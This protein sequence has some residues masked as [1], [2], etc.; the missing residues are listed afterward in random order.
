MLAAAR[1]GSNKAWAALV[2]RVDPECRR[3]AHLVLGGH[4]V[5]RALLSAY[6]RAYR[7]RRKG[8]PDAV[9]FLTHHVWIACGHEI[10]RHQRREAPAPGRRAIRTDRRPR[11]G[12]DALGQAVAGLRPEERAVWGLVDEA[13]F[14]VAAV[15]QALG[16]DPKV[17][18]T[19]ASRVARLI[20]EALEEPT[21]DMAVLGDDDDHPDLGEPGDDTSAVLATEPSTA[22][23][24][25]TDEDEPPIEPEDAGQ[26]EPDPPDAAKHA[27]SA[28]GRQQ[29]TQ[30][31]AIGDV[32]ASDRS[33]PVSD[34]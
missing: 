1:Q 5:D 14:P 29:R 25:S 30:F 34:G 7:A 18:T 10:R 20:D 3:L 31:A 28:S 22:E 4:D 24:P 21:G 17:V 6:V 16:V 19:V 9:V 2:E 11:L 27:D 8:P 23:A 12:A 15:A 33:E 26:I 13:G 32:A